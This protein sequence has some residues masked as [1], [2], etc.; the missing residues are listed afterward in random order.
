MLKLIWALP[1]CIRIL[2]TYLDIN[3]HGNKLDK[4]HTCIFLAKTS[5]KSGKQ[6]SIDKEIMCICQQPPSG[7]MIQCNWCQEWFHNK[8]MNIKRDDNILFW[9]CLNCRT[10]PKIVREI[11]NQLLLLSTCNQD[12]TKSLVDKTEMIQSLQ[13]ENNRL[14]NMINSQH[15]NTQDSRA[16]ANVNVPSYKNILANETASEDNNITRPSSSVQSVV[17][18]DAKE[19]STNEPLSTG[20]KP[21]G[22]LLIG[23]SIIRDINTTRFH[24]DSEPKCIRGGKVVDVTAELL[25]LPSDCFLENIIIQVG[26]NDCTGNLFDS[27]VFYD[28]YVTL[29]L[30]AKTICQ[31]VVISG[32]CP[33]LDDSLGNINRANAILQKIA[34]DESLYFVDN[35]R[36]FRLLNGSVNTDY[37][38]KDGIHLSIKGT[39]KLAK[40][41]GLSPKSPPRTQHFIDN[42]VNRP[43]GQLASRTEKPKSVRQVN[44]RASNDHHDTRRKFSGNRKSNRQDDRN[45]HEDIRQRYQSSQDYHH[46]YHSHT[47]G[48]QDSYHSH[49]CWYCGESNHTHHSC[50]H[51]QQLLCHECHKYGHKAKFCTF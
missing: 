44:N 43:K 3:S 41:L 26:S 35:D 47:S 13:D 39:F 30:K 15:S 14:R 29:V 38:R 37:Y 34:N 25:K 11:Q 8:C 22:T 1:I 4:T 19:Y 23:S 36:V 48:R 28:D 46:S 20:Q 21:K 33:R 32:L 27:D 16:A 5:R 31:N 12:L 10:L 2:S 7:K 24:L 40:N 18:D 49:S 45:A 50:K 42:F 9:I 51:G 17:N 6:K